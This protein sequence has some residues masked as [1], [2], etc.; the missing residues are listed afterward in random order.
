M[1]D[2]GTG[3]AV[4]AT[5]TITE[6]QVG[7]FE[8]SLRFRNADYACLQGVGNRLVTI[9]FTMGSDIAIEMQCFERLPDGD[10]SWTPGSGAVCP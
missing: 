8:V 5:V 3:A 2:A 7:E 6:L 4:S 1:I 9:A 10:L